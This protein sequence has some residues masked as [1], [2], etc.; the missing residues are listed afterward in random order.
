MY[1][2]AVAFTNE[3]TVAVAAVVAA[4]ITVVA[5]VAA[6]A[7]AATAVPTDEV[8]LSMSLQRFVLQV[9]LD[10]RLPLLC[11]RSAYIKPH[12]CPYCANN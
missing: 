9:P 8:A 1:S 7:A 3:G 6:T 11:N 2:A 12:S 5:V 4:A 10:D